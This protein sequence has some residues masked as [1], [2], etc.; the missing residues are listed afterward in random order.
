MDAGHYGAKFD[1]GKPDFSL[2]PPRA[3]EELARVL[4]FG[5]EKYEAFSWKLVPDLH[6]RYLAAAFRHLNAYQRHLWDNDPAEDSESG[7][8]HLAHAACCMFFIAEMDL[9]LRE[10]Q[11]GGLDQN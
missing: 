2:I 6:R 1:R 11:D 10:E 5:A 7:L 8:H 9:A 4:S 3:A